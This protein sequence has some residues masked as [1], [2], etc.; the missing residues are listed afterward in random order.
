[1]SK[2]RTLSDT[3]ILQMLELARVDLKS[4][5]QEDIP[6]LHVNGKSFG[7]LGN[8]S[9][10]TGRAK[11]R[12]TFSVTIAVAAAMSGD[13]Q[14]VIKGTFPEGKH[15]VILFDTEQSRGHVLKMTKRIST[16]INE[17]YP[18]NLE[19][20]AL[21]E[22]DHE[23]RRAMI[24]KKIQM[25]EHLGLVVI[26]GAR[27]LV[28]SINSEDEATHC[29]QFLMNLSQKYNIHIIT[30]LHQN[31]ASDHVRGH[32]GTELQNKAETV[33]EVK[34]SLT[35][36]GISKFQALMTRNI[37]FD[38]FQFRVN[39]DGIPVIDTN[40]TLVDEAK[41]LAK[42]AAGDYPTSV[43][44]RIIDELD[45]GTAY[46]RKAIIIKLREVI[47]D[48]TGTDYGETKLAEFL[49]YYVEEGYL[50]T[51]GTP[52]SKTVRYHVK[53]VPLN[54][55]AADETADTDETGET[56]IVTPEAQPEPE[57]KEEY[58]KYGF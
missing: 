6:V 9:V 39:D 47:K 38:G 7:T 24:F 25:T 19:V 56:E 10:V 41:T 30:V 36:K 40:V 14:G 34:L 11:S 1:M 49:T 37:E 20:F 16:L 45:N 55:E 50:K 46:D 52:G 8:F 48:V 58:R 32:L 57:K 5:I 17:E 13:V 28:S 12:K 51:S 29:S 4:N 21:R 31:K 27:D 53:S 33:V 23:Q 2:K 18:E 35:D 26:D 43:H 42:L 3:Q 22:F 15:K 54:N 44:E